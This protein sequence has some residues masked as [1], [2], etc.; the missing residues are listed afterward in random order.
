MVLGK[1]VCPFVRSARLIYCV[2]RK[3]LVARHLYLC[4]VVFV[5]PARFSLVPFVL[6]VFRGRRRRLLAIVVK[7]VALRTYVGAVVVRVF[8]DRYVVVVVLVSPLPRSVVLPYSEPKLRAVYYY[9]CA[10]KPKNGNGV[11]PVYANVR[12]K[13]RRL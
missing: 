2:Q 10:R 1:N 12:R 13:P 6:R 3:F 5:V 11:E 9:R 7:S 8:S 4:A